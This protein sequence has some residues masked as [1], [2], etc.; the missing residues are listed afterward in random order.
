MTM[1]SSLRLLNPHSYN[2]QLAKCPS[3]ILLNVVV[4]EDEDEEEGNREQKED[5]LECV[6]SHLPS[7]SAHT[8]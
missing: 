2:N 3:R 4:D 7:S 6:Y 8:V 1:N 5:P